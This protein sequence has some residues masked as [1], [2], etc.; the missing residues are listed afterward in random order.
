MF[1]ISMF[2]LILFIIVASFMLAIVGFVIFP[3]F[4][5]FTLGK[6]KGRIE[7]IREEKEREKEAK[8]CYWR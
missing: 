4:I 7:E 5:A 3:W 1:E 6:K 8:R 2:F